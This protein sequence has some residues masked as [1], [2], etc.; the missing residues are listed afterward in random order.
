[1]SAHLEKELRLYTDHHEAQIH[2]SVPFLTNEMTKALPGKPVTPPVHTRRGGWERMPP[3]VSEK[4]YECFPRSKM[5]HSQKSPRDISQVLKEKRISPTS[6]HLQLY[7]F[8]QASLGERITENT[9]N[10]RPTNICSACHPLYVLCYLATL[11][12]RV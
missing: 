8:Y 2:I 1:M 9:L 11:R 12:S 4:C 6:S 5:E 3:P 10:D 7:N